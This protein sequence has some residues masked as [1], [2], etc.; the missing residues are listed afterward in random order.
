[1]NCYVTDFPD[2]ELVKHPKVICVPHLGASTPESE[3]NCAVMAVNQVKDYLEN[4]NIKN[5]VNF[6]ETE[7]NRN[8]GTRLCI[9][10]KN[11]PKMV[12]QITTVLA[13]EDI[14]IEDMLNRHHADIA[15]NIIDVNQDISPKQLE[16]IKNIKGVIRVRVIPAV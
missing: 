13:N 11:I 3:T 5:S 10:N 7:M 8:G 15:Y 14:N 1:M 9:V 16:I 12:G 6:P 4:G 2:G